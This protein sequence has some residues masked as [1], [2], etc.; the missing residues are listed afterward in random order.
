MADTLETMKRKMA[1]SVL[2]MGKNTPPVAICVLRKG[3][4]KL[5]WCKSLEILAIST[6]RRP[7]SPCCQRLATAFAKHLVSGTHRFNL[8]YYRGYKNLL[9]DFLSSG[10][11]AMPGQAQ[12]G[13]RVAKLIWFQAT[14][15]KH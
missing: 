10:I 8:F 12:R 1:K 9:T 3:H 2:N 15:N 13:I 4:V 14:S 6:P 7:C 5:T 11:I